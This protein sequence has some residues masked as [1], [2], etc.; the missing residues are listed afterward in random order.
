MS[1][2][3]RT[4]VAIPIP[5]DRAERLSRLQSLIAPTLTGARWVEPAMF[6]VTL[7]FLG[8]VPDAGLNP[9]CLAAA[10]AA[11]GFHGLALKITGLGVFPNPQRPRVVWAGLEGDDLDR[12]GTLQKA[13]ASAVASAGYPPEDDRFSAHVTLGRLKPGR[14]PVEDCT[15]LLRHYAR[16]SAGPLVVDEI[17][18]YAS[19]LTPEGP[20][21]VALGRAPLKGR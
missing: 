3:T 15:P 18:T 14:D 4:F 10:E 8:D 16:W 7:A 11:K 6:H 20:A 19:Q 9:V 1:R 12:L 13:I 17:V 21:Y 5:P 2:P